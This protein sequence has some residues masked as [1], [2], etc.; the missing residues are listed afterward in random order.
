MVILNQN[1][2]LENLEALEVNHC[3]EF[4]EAAYFS[5][6][7]KTTKKL[8]SVL[9]LNIRSARRNFD[10][11]IAAI[12]TYN[13]NI[14]D[15]IILSECFQ[16]ES[17]DYFEIPGYT[18]Y[19]NEADYNKNDGVLMFI[20]SNIN[21]LF[22]KTKLVISGVTLGILKF[23]IGD[24]HYKII[25][26]YRPNPT[27]EI[28]FINE[29]D[30]YLE[31]PEKDNQVQIIVGD[32]NINILNKNDNI[33]NEYL[34]TLAKHGFKAYI[35]SPTRVTNESSSCL[36]HMFVKIKHNI[37]NIKCLSYIL[38]CNIT[39]HY[40]VAINLTFDN[41]RVDE[42]SNDLQVIA[43]TNFNK[44]KNLFKH[45]C[46]QDV[47]NSNDVKIA[48][49]KFTDIFSNLINQSTSNIGKLNK[50]NK[51]IKPWISEG[52]IT[53]IKERDKLKKRLLES[54]SEDLEK[55]Y[56]TYRNYLNTL[57]KKSK[58]N[59]YKNQ[60]LQNQKNLKK[61]YEIIS[62]ATNN[63]LDN[64]KTEI[65]LVDNDGKPFDNTKQM[66][67]YCNDYF[68]NIGSNMLSNISE[69]EN[70]CHSLENISNSMF[71]TPVTENEII[72]HINSLKNQS[73]PG[74]DGVTTKILKLIH[75]HILSPLVHIINLSF[76]TGIVPHQFKISI[77]TPIHKS[78]DKTLI[79]NYRPISLIS[80][81]SK[82]FEKCLKERLTEFLKTNNV[83]HKNQFAFIEGMGTCDAMY[84]VTK[85]ITNSLDKNK[86][87]IG[88]FLDLA[89]AFD[90][91]NH[92]KLLEVLSHYGVRGIVSDVF[93]NYLTNRT[94][95][96]RIKNNLS[97][98]S[99]IKIGVPQGTVLGPILFVIYINSLLKLDIN[100]KVFSYADD[101]VALFN[102][103]TWNAAKENVIEGIQI[104]KKW[105][106]KYQLS[107]NV[108][109]TN[110]IAFSVTNH[111]RPDYNSIEI[112]NLQQKI[113]EVD[114]IKYLGI[115]I[116][117]HLKW[118]QHIDY[119]TNRV[120]KIIF[121]FY[122]LKDIL[123]RNILILIYKAFVESLFRYGI[124]VWGGLY[125]RS[126]KK[127]NVIQNS[128]LKIMYNK[129]RD[130]P[131]KLLYTNEI[132][133]IRSLYILNVCIYTHKKDELKAFVNNIYNTRSTAEEH[134]KIPTSSK[135]VNKRFVTYLSPKF[136]NLIPLKIRLLRS[137]KN[138]CNTC[139]KYITDNYA[140]FVR[141][142][143]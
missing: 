96:V 78:G 119:L 14:C 61:I 76:K 112:K 107:L 66:A 135:N 69:P 115:I 64:K 86:K 5:A 132:L 84:E 49:N 82:I 136:Y 72:K 95:H 59:Y 31:Q 74:I 130:Y 120:R 67:D 38:N 91:V 27:N 22:T 139:K 45:Q 129:K 89:K 101:T 65:N 138:F 47:L 77:I 2:V 125:T 58:N 68:A 33:V 100:A 85:E 117:K 133:N 42:K 21:S 94:Q 126:L 116:D 122:Q 53:S 44:L 108:K 114:E 10:E 137:F 55:E 56:K 102:G 63:N 3:G 29:I 28:P 141:L 12:E 140:E 131:T 54:Y 128:I 9:H 109:K 4:R 87:C 110:Y 50:K 15:V 41:K 124:L 106:D 60:V 51:K 18:T 81:F 97:D 121:K 40:P 75:S 88:V 98:A 13:L 113:K 7:T 46:W 142:L 23:N 52:L 93:K 19:Y 20:R 134:I 37:K 127:L 1:L 57:L 80:N 99:I 34:S 43:K 90:T 8:L 16:I 24:I 105:L 83:L 11:L 30:S 118:T 111:N 103:T 104:I 35:Q 79:S 92:E 6:V 62:E 71:L 143:E 32:I 25:A 36:D 73:A 123:N 17:K 70:F 48:T 39:D 26:L